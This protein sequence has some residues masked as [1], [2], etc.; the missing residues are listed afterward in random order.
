MNFLFY[1][2]AGNTSKLFLEKSACHVYSQVTMKTEV[3]LVDY[4]REQF[5][6]TSSACSVVIMVEKKITC[7]NIIFN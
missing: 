7:Q 5:T 4:H 2:S 3:G 6:F 1:P